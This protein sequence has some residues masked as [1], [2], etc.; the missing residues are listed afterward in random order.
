MSQCDSEIFGAPGCRVPA[1]QIHHTA[2]HPPPASTPAARGGLCSGHGAAALACL[3]GSLPCAAPATR[4]TFP[5]AVTPVSFW[6]HALC[7]CPVLWVSARPPSYRFPSCPYALPEHLTAVA[8]L[9]PLRHSPWAVLVS[10]LTCPWSVFCQLRS[11]LLSC[12]YNC[13]WPMEKVTGS[14]VGLSSPLLCLRVWVAL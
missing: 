4:T 8:S 14:S 2:V 1:W 12:P 10:L 11:A 9:G 13:A 6:P 5:S 3:P 7:T